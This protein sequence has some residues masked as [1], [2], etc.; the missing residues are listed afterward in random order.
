MDNIK[1][2]LINYVHG[3]DDTKK[4]CE[5]LLNWEKLSNFLSGNGHGDD[6]FED[7]V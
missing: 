2:V 6:T 1:T 5:E 4:K 7:V 3:C